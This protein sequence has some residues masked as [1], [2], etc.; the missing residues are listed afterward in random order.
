MTNNNWSRLQ[1]GG[2]PP[3]LAGP[4]ESTEEIVDSIP[5]DGSPGSRQRLTTFDAA[6]DKDSWP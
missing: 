6:N 1:G 4:I 2:D 5:R 3:D